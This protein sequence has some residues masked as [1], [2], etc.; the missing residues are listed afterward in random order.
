MR[1][2]RLLVLPPFHDHDAVIVDRVGQR[3]A[4]TQTDGYCSR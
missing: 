3:L 4:S 1:G 2:E